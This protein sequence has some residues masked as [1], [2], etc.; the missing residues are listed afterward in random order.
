[1]R[2]K[3]MIGMAA[4]AALLLARNLYTMLLVL[5]DEALQGAIYRIIFFHVPAAWTALLGATVAAVGSALYLATKK[6]KYDSFAASAIEVGLVFGAANLATG[7]IWGRII[8]GIWWTW[9]VRLNSM[10]VA[11]L[12]YAA[13]VALR[14]AIDDPTLRAR[15]SAVVAIFAFVDAPIIIFSIRWWRT[16]HPGPALW[17]GGQM[18]PAMKSVLFLNWIPLLL[19]AAIFVMIRMEQERNQREIEALRRYAHAY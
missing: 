18:D 4:A 17:G 3:L 14:R 16:Q 9:D 13:Y 19:L 6:L 2:Q 11:W 7:M 12:V 10:L 5:P 15:I 1:M 8:W